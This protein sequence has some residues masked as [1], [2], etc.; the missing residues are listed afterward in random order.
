MIAVWLAA[1]GILVP[2]VISGPLS[3][4][5]MET[6]M[7]RVEAFVQT[8]QWGDALRVLEEM[9]VPSEYPLR[10]AQRHH[11]RGVVLMKLGRR[12]DAA[13][14]FREAYSYDS[15]DVEAC[16]LVG[17]LAVERGEFCESLQWLQR[18]EAAEPGRE[19]VRRLVQIAEA[20]CE[21]G[22]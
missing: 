2:K 22:D 21:D 3:D 9:R 7:R 4:A 15:S 11:N 19:D 12:N 14:A 17:R 16:V 1:L 18:A 8:G 13:I 20:N 10:N 5:E 6:E